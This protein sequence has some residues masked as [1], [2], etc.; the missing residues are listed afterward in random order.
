M[1]A[2]K[3][4]SYEKKKNNRGLWKNVKCACTTT[5]GQQCKKSLS[6]IYI[7]I[8]LYTN[9]YVYTHSLSVP[10]QWSKNGLHFAKCCTLIVEFFLSLHLSL[11]L[12]LPHSHTRSH[13]V[14]PQKIK[15]HVSME[16]SLISQ[17]N[18]KTAEKCV[19]NDWMLVRATQV[20]VSEGIPHHS[21]VSNLTS[22]QRIELC[23]WSSRG[24]KLEAP[25]FDKESKG[26]GRQAPLRTDLIGRDTHDQ[27]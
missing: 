14:A 15:T 6:Y 19:G 5:G 17:A 18:K 11:S 25:P 8:Y 20:T 22:A 9:L 3:K 23:S 7:C 2:L 1:K 4:K 26:V 24:L 12:S 10:Q 13:K 16:I 21:C 27:R